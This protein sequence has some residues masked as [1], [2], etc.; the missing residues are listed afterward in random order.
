[1]IWSSVGVTLTIGP[2][3]VLDTAMKKRGKMEG[4]LKERTGIYR[5]Y[6]ASPLSGDS[7]DHL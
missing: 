7:I 3:S 4:W 1:M 5:I 2:V 6:G